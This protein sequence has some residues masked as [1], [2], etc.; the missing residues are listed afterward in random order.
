[1]IAAL[2][3]GVKDAL[4]LHPSPYDGGVPQTHAIAMLDGNYKKLLN[5]GTKLSDSAFAAFIGTP[6]YDPATVA[7]GSLVATPATPVETLAVSKV[8]R[9]TSAQP[10]VITC[11][12]LDYFSVPYGNQVVIFD[13]V[14][15]VE[16][17]SVFTFSDP[18]D[19]GSLVY[20]TSMCQPVGLL[21]ADS[22]AGGPYNAGSAWLNTI[23]DVTS[24]L[25][26]DLVV[27]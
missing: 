1:M 7:H 17:S 4:V 18:G 15:Q 5:G 10:G 2:D 3:V 19:S 26:V 25:G 21:F 8:G 23:G 11:K 14:I 20:T 16:S 12:E 9:T 27:A 22:D 24:D 13:N 6:V